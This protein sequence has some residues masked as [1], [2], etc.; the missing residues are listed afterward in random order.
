[1]ITLL[2]SAYVVFFFGTCSVSKVDFLSLIE[3]ILI[4]IYDAHEANN[5]MWI[6]THLYLPVLPASILVFFSSTQPLVHN[7]SVRRRTISSHQLVKAAPAQP[8]RVEP[9][10]PQQDV[11]ILSTVNL[12]T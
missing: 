7:P 4:C 3:W 8:I 9:K 6:L 10:V 11:V 2:Y 5:R 12:Q 1:M